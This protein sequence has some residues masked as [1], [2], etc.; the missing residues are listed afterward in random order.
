MIYG[1][2]FDRFPLDIAIQAFETLARTNV[3]LGVREKADFCGLIHPIH[4]KG[5][6][7]AWEIER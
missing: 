2:D 7:F 3:R 5:S 4:R 1:Y 6:V